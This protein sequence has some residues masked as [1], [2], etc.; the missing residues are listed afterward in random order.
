MVDAD[1]PSEPLPTATV[2]EVTSQPAGSAPSLW[3]PPVN[4]TH[5]QA[6]QEEVARRMLFEESEAFAGDANGTG[7]NPGLQVVINLKDDIPVQ[8]TYST[9]PFPKSEVKEYI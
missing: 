7:C 6:E 2:N 1:S 3:H 4:L 5:L 9:C 8:R